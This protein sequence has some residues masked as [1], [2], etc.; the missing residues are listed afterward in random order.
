MEPFLKPGSF[1]ER[2]PIDRKTKKVGVISFSHEFGHSN[3]A[4]LIVKLPIMQLLLLI[5]TSSDSRDLWPVIQ[6][7]NQVATIWI[8]SGL[9]KVYSPCYGTMRQRYPVLNGH[10]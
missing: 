8:I 4:H 6:S 2:S 5:L 9:N 3:D 10:V 1:I 7:L